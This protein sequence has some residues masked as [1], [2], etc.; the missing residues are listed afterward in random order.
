MAYRNPFIQP[1]NHISIAGRDVMGDFQTIDDL[2]LCGVTNN[3]WSRLQPQSMFVRTLF[4]SK[5]MNDF[6][7]SREDSTRETSI[8]IFLHYLLLIPS[9]SQ[10]YIL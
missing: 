1:Q 8:P 4:G 3:G 2:F 6:F 7:Q 9:Y 10:L 5:V